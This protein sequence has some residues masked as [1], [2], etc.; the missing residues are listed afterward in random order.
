MTEAAYS[1]LSV[2][3]VAFRAAPA[4]LPRKDA[5]ADLMPQFAAAQICNGG[6]SRPG[7]RS[8]CGKLVG[9]PHNG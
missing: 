6:D 1:V 4:K 8:G 9:V 7:L 2:E 5:E 3:D